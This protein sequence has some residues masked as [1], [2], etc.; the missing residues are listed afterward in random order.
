MGRGV[1]YNPLSRSSPNI[2]HQ[3]G[4]V[5]YWFAAGPVLTRSSKAFGQRVA[6]V[7]GIRRVYRNCGGSH[8]PRE[9]P[10]RGHSGQASALTDVDTILKAPQGSWCR[11][12]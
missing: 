8:R 6:L 5:K 12:R 10:R 3:Q 4:E 1:T 2:L 7:G 11:S 9:L